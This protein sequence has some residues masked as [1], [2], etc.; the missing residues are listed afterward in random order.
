MA[1]TALNNLIVSVINNTPPDPQRGGLKDYC[2]VL[3]LG[4]GDLV[5]PLLAN[6]HG[7]PISI[8][9]LA[10]NPRGRRTVLVERFDR[11]QKKNIQV[12]ETQSYWIDYIANSR[13]TEMALALQAASQAIQDWL[14][15]DFK[16]SQSFPPIIVNITDGDHNGEGDPVQAADR[17]RDIATNDGHALL[18]CCH[19]TSTGMQRLVFPKTIQQIDV[20]IAN[21]DE[22]T[23]ARQLFRMSSE[24]PIT[25]VRK[26]RASFNAG[27]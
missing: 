3:V 26:A 16:R 18:F 11:A 15:A 7:M 2:D 9:E 25:M 22:R 5:T 10:A 24:I 14:R 13:R 17:L 27:L 19:L 23:W 4:Y 12:K 1:T 21:V 20:Q 6:G 8:R